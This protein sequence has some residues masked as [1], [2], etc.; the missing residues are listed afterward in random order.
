MR[1]PCGH[2]GRDLRPLPRLGHNSFAFPDRVSSIHHSPIEPCTTG[3]SAAGEGRSPNESHSLHELV[4]L[5]R[6][7]GHLTHE[8]IRDA[9]IE[10]PPASSEA[11]CG[12]A[13]SPA[14]RTDLP[15]SAGPDERDATQITDED[16]SRPEREAVGD[17]MRTY[18]RQLG[19]LPRLTREQEIEISQR[20][21]IAERHVQTH[22]NRFG[23]IT[24]AY[25]DVAQCALEGGERL[26]H[27]VL[28]RMVRNRQRYLRELPGLCARVEAAALRCA[29]SYH[30]S[31]EQRDEATRAQSQ[32]DFVEANAVLQ[33]LYPRF[34]FQQRVVDRI[35]HSVEET[36]RLI[37]RW[38]EHTQNRA[39]GS[40]D[41]LPDCEARL[42][43]QRLRTWMTTEE[44]LLEYQQLKQWREK[45]HSARVE[46]VEANLRLVVT[47]A[48]S[49]QAHGQSLLDLIQEGNIG[50]MKA[51]ERF[52]Y[53]RGYKFS[54][55]ATWWIRQAMSRGVAGQGRT[56]RI[57][58]HVI[59]MLARLLRVQK[60]L[61]QESGHDATPEEVVEEVQLPVDR[62]RSVLSMAQQPISLH[63]PVGENDSATVGDFIEDS[64][65]RDP[66]HTV[67]LSLLKERMKQLLG[68]LTARERHVLEQ[69]FGLVDGRT[70]TLEELGVEFRLCR[71]RVRQ[72]EATA[73]RKMRHPERW[74]HLADF[75]V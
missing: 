35:A 45:A 60:Q 5:A 32:N 20:I 33:R 65:A 72:I 43:E 38:H 14:T 75:L 9:L 42:K 19:R 12:A 71:E 50:L 25:L 59:E 10:P 8:E 53:R 70:R 55:Y 52:E 56:I 74:R 63:M 69:R 27:I 62:V 26:D 1:T 54:T 58:A 41:S 17:S 28:G 66:S 21:E 51:V 31:L 2:L 13:P 18:L 36:Q 15:E 6:E 61:G 46:M 22:L 68:T 49:Y 3:A 34:C 44:F 11:D 73:L 47:I 16:E 67:A 40:P 48:K 29:E 64:D 57:P 4:S 24:R 23:F 30:A 7:Q 37:L 39:P